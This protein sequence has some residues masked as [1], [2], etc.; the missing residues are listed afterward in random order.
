MSK[1]LFYCFAVA[2]LHAHGE[3]IIISEI[4]GNSAGKGRDQGKEWIEL[5]NLSPDVILVK[6]LI[7]EI[8]NSEDKD[9][10]FT[11]SIS[12]PEPLPFSDYLLIAQEKDLGLTRCMKDEIAVLVVPEFSIKNE[13]AQKICIA[14][15]DHSKSCTKITKKT[16]MTDG[17][18]LFRELSDISEVPL[19]RNEPCHLMDNVFASPGL[20]ARFCVENQNVEELFQKCEQENEVVY[21]TVVN[22]VEIPIDQSSK[23]SLKDLE[24]TN[25]GE[26]NIRLS[27]R[28]ERKDDLWLVGLC[29]APRDTKKICHMLFDH[30]NISSKRVINYALNVWHKNMGE[31]L[32]V[33]L[34][35]MRFAQSK[36]NLNTIK[37]EKSDTAKTSWNPQFLMHTKNGNL[38]IR[39][40]LTVEELP[41]NLSLLTDTNQIIAQWSF[42]IEGEKAC[43]IPINQKQTP[44]FLKFAGRQGYIT[45]PVTKG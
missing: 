13:G 32:F 2:C 5:A 33:M 36:F 20:P 3:Q 39:L 29:A 37:L 4:F 38:E 30:Q 41:L 34:S 17:V 25:D 11:K 28:D 24:I 18:S 27:M 7:V 10:R 1:L 9:F 21:E 35:N 8:E 16:K 45:V 40:S 19:W 15:N 12:L 6:S 26:K 14:I 43:D 31:D 23:I 42:L 44:A 22:K